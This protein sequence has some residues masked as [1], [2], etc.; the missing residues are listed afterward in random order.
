MCAFKYSEK[1]NIPNLF[2]K[3]TGM[4]GC[5]WAEDFFCVVILSLKPILPKILTM[6]EMGVMNK[7]ECFYN[8]KEKGCRLCLHKQ[9]LV[10]T[11]RRETR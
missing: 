7:P 2:L 8:V 6:E 4:A 11:K 10:L 3:E 9:P 5:A 1:N